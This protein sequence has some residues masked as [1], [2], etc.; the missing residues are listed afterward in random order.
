MK[1]LD[2]QTLATFSD[3]FTAAREGALVSR[4]IT[5]SRK[6]HPGELFVAL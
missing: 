4:V 6:V 3:G 2:Y 1:P 5:D